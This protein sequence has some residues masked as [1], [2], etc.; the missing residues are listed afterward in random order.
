MKRNIIREMLQWKNMEKDRMP[1]VLYGARQVGKTYTLQ[2]F[3]RD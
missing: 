2:R 1:L 3:G